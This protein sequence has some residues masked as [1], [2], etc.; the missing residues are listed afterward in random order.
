MTKCLENDSM[1]RKQN[2]ECQFRMQLSPV[3]RDPLTLPA[4]GVTVNLDS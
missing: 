4:D 1:R 2:N 3:G